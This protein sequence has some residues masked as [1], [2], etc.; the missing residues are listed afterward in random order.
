MART[1]IEV[2]NELAEV[3]G[4]KNLYFQP[5]ETIKLKYPCIVYV[6][7]GSNNDKADNIDYI[8]R[9]RYTVTYIDLDPDSVKPDQLE[10]LDYCSFDRFF[11]ADNLNHWVFT[12]YR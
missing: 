11:T 1:R 6:R 2:H 8:N 4:S 10:Q 3:L 12:L 7:S 5:P 9:K